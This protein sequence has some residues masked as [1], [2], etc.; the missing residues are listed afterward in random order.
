[1]LT[2]SH[3]CDRYTFLCYNLI[4]FCNC[5]LSH[6]ATSRYSKCRTYDWSI[7]DCIYICNTNDRRDGWIAYYNKVVRISR[8][9]TAKNGLNNQCIKINLKLNKILRWLHC[10]CHWKKCIFNKFVHLINCSLTM[11]YNRSPD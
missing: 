6:L 8:E 3:I 4:C 9:V 10:L 2:G 1:M 7:H 5:S 11:T